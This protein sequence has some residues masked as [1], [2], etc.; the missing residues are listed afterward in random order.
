ML[1]LD[2]K[3]PTRCKFIKRLM[4]D[5]VGRGPDSSEAQLRGSVSAVV[6]VVMVGI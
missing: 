2:L 3:R 4:K 6:L 5:I 1:E